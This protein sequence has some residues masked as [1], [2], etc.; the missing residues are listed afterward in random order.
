MRK[1]GFRSVVLVVS[2]VFAFGVLASPREPRQNPVVKA[3][4]KIRAL[5]DL[6]TVPTPAPKP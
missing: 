2:A 1:L 3:V 6:I 4:K 5:G